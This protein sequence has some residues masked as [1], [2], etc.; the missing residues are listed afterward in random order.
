MH[1]LFGDVAERAVE[2]LREF[3][4]AEGYYLAYSGGKDSDVLLHLARQSG[5][6][7]D[8][9][10]HLT[11]CDPPE[12]VRHVKTQADVTIERPAETMWQLIRRKGMPPR[13]NVRFCC[14]VLKEGGGRARLVLTG[15]RW[16]ESNRRSQRRMV[17]SCLRDRSKRYLHPIIDWSTDE[18][19]RYIRGEKIPYCRL[20]DE[21]FSRLGCVLC[22]MATDVERQMQRWPALALAWERAIKATW[23]PAKPALRVFADAEQYWQWWLDRRARAADYEMPLFFRD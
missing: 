7:F 21:G 15:V 6:R 10:H 4:P 20:Y 22:P 14:E 11:T 19:W 9:H 16:G 17:E 12:L 1:D 23:D 5:V 2:R 13:R 8:A 18:I 3:E